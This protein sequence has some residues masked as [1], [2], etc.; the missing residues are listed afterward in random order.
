MSH[1]MV[2]ILTSFRPKPWCLSKLT[3]KDL[4]PIIGLTA[5]LGVSVLC[6]PILA[7]S[8]RAADVPA[9]IPAA[10]PAKAPAAPAYSWTGCYVG[11]NAGAAASGS[12]FT[13]SVTPGTHLVNPADLAAVDAAGTGSANDSRFIEGGQVGCNWQTGM[14][15]FGVEGDLDS[16]STRSTSTVNGTLTTGDAFTITN[17]VKTNWL[18]TVRPRVGVAADRSLV[19]VTGGVA[20]TNYS[21]TQTYVDTLSA[22]AGSSSASSNATGWTVGGGWETAW[23]H[24]WIFRAEYLFAKFRSISTNG[25]L[26]DTS[27]GTNALRGSADLTAQVL[28]VGMNY[29]F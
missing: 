17:S 16:F 4:V 19:Y 28:R 12:D 25:A 15:V 7:S 23:E 10:M 2:A 11:A 1:R 5:G 22:A 24:N 29:K 8:A 27:G 9:K 3:A 18:G 21:Y 6:A 20:F 26:L 13:T 14:L